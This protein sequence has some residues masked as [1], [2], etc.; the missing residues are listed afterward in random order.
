[1]RVLQ[2]WNLATIYRMLASSTQTLSQGSHQV[3]K[4]MQNR[5]KINLIFNVNHTLKSCGLQ[6]FGNLVRSINSWPTTSTLI[7]Q[8]SADRVSGLGQTVLSDRQSVSTKEIWLWSG[9]VGASPVDWQDNKSSLALALICL[10]C[11]G[12]K[13]EMTLPCFCF[14]PFP[15]LVL[16]LSVQRFKCNQSNERMKTSTVREKAVSQKTWKFVITLDHI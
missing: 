7:L 4:T 9:S 2:N 3:H 11:A 16:K 5:L 10:S 13:C 8:I 1:M 12:V 6:N 14:F 15:L